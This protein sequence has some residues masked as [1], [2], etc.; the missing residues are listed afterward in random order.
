MKT[1]K[2]SK[3]QKCPH[4]GASMAIHGH[5]LS[6]GLVNGLIKL[7]TEVI[8]RNRNMIHF[9]D[10]MSLTKSEFCNF[11]KLRYHGLIAKYIDPTTDEHL[12]GYWLL[13]KRGNQFCKNEIALPASVFTF[14]NKIVSRSEDK[15]KLS[16]V[17]KNTELPYW[18]EASAFKVGYADL[19]D[20]EDI[21]FDSNGQGLMF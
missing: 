6:K 15:V 20:I 13:T 2:K 14:R 12:A 19:M 1:S 17:L 21:K 10:E 4:C 9:K 18:D 11:Q 7:K 3:A 16:D 8:K 5:R